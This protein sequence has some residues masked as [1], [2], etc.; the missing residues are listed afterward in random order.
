MPELPPTPNEL[1][2]LLKTPPDIINK[3]QAFDDQIAAL[4]DRLAD[5]ENRRMEERFLWLLAFVIFFD[6]MVLLESENWSAPIIIGV[7]QLIGLIIVANRCRVDYIMPLI[8]RVCGAI[9]QR[10][11]NK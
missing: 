9:S 3:T 2:G 11:G 1:K 6:A 7:L 8:D 10:N 4:N 5:S